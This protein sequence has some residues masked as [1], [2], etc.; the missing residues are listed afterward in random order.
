MTSERENNK[1]L[2]DF[3]GTEYATIKAYVNSRIKASVDTDPEDI[4]QDVALKLFTGAD[5]YSPINNVAGF[6]YRSIKNKIIDIMRENRPKNNSID[7]N[8]A[9]LMEFAEV[10]YD[11][12]DNSYSEQMKDELKS[13]I[14]SLKPD[15]RDII[16]AIDF[17][18]YTYKE[19]A[20]E[21]AIPEGT[22]MSRRHRA[23]SL[24]F[25]KLEIKIIE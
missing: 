1:K 2:K 5:R 6:V 24:L 22:L 15:Y 14:M 25:K 13:S 4:I 16:I 9:K 20:L 7:E 8:E 3:F 17:E 19:I 10:F 23:I 18:G 11:V 12:P 21:T